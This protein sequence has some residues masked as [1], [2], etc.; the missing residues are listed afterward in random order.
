MNPIPLLPKELLQSVLSFVS[1]NRPHR[2]LTK[3][4]DLVQWHPSLRERELREPGVSKSFNLKGLF[5]NSISWA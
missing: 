1:R 4:C 5:W 2:T 3:T